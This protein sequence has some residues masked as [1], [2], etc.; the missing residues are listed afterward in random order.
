MSQRLFAIMLWAIAQ[1]ETPNGAHARCGHA[2]ETGKYQ[3][4]P[5]VRLERG[6]ELRAA[7]LPVTDEN[8]ARWQLIWINWQLFSH[9]IAQTP[10][11]VGLAWN[12]GVDAEL[13]H[14]SSAQAKDYAQRLTNLVEERERQ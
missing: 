4:T 6:A 5:D 3:L 2:H 10:Y 9:H 8:I 12:G 13:H 7:N 14:T 11:N 1:M